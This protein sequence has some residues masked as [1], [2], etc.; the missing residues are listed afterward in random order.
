MPT[1][2][3]DPIEVPIAVLEGLES[4]RESGEANMQDS[5]KVQVIAAYLGYPE[6]VAWIENHSQEY[7]EGIFRGFVATE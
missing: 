7:Q 1:R 2:F 3:E 4:V 5:A 6:A